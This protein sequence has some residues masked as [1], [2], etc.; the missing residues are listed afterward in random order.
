MANGEIPT[1]DQTDLGDPL[2][3]LRGPCLD[4][5]TSFPQHP[6]KRE[7][8]DQ[9]INEGRGAEMMDGFWMQ[10]C[11]FEEATQDDGQIHATLSC[12]GVSTFL[13]RCRLQ[14]VQ[15]DSNGKVLSKGTWQG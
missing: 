13:R 7:I 12:R 4:L 6:E 5:Q 1:G 2:V 9:H 14:L 15:E 11:D 8:C 3:V 10:G